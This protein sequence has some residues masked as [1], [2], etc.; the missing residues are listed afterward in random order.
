MG[1]RRSRG[2]IAEG[3][4]RQDAAGTGRQ[5][6]LS[7]RAIEPFDLG[8]KVPWPHCG[9][10]R[11]SGRDVRYRRRR[12]TFGFTADVIV[13]DSDHR[14][15]SVPSTGLGTRQG[16]NPVALPRVQS[17]R[18]AEAVKP[19]MCAPAATGKPRNFR[20][21]S[22]PSAPRSQTFRCVAHDRWKG[23]TAD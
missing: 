4:P 20:P 7:K 14:S 11:V 15:R 9:R 5:V 21:A 22:R 8:A 6:P 2:R 18:L 3:R 23:S 19:A 17:G 12:D 16:A 10:L 1:Q 13:I